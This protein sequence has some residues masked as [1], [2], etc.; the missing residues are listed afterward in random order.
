M[1]NQNSLMLKRKEEKKAEK[2]GKAQRMLTIIKVLSSGNKSSAAE[3]I[4]MFDI[5]ERTIY[6]DLSDLKKWVCRSIMTMD[7]KS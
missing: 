5:T 2:F 6:R 4:K 3:L 1:S 7:K